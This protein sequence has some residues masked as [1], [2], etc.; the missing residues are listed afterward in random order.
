MI[1]GLE[2]S[3]DIFSRHLDGLGGKD[4]KKDYRSE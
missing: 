1:L 3:I 2:M 4:G